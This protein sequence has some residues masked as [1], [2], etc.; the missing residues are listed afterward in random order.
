MKAAL[1]LAGVTLGFSAAVIGIIVLAV[2]LRRGDERA[3]RSGRRYVFLVL[4]G[5]VI[6]AGA[7]EWALVT[8]DFSLRYVADNGSR[9][10]PMLYTVASLWGA[11]QGSILLW[12]LVL[13]GYASVTARP[14]RHRAGHPAVAAAALT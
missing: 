2:G 11:L 3:L 8:H 9:E 13:A 10:T 1:G 4:L 6:A 14:F 7:M 5:A 12:A